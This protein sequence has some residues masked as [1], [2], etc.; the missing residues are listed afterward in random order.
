MALNLEIPILSDHPLI[1]AQTRPNKIKVFLEQLPV[2]NPFEAA[3]LLLEEIEI[4]NRQKVAVDTRINVLEIYRPVIS[5]FQK[6]LSGHYCKAKVPLSAKTKSYADM[7]KSLYLELGYGYKIALIN[8]QEKLFGI[9]NK[10]SSALCAQRALEALLNITIVYY[11][12]YLAVPGNVWAELNR[13][14]LHANQEA[15]EDIE[16][17]IGNQKKSTVAMTF[18]QML[19]MQ[20]SIPQNLSQADIKLTAEYI[21]KNA[22]YASIEPYSAPGLRTHN[23]ADNSN[24]QHQLAAAKPPAPEFIVPLATELPPT[25]LRAD[26]PAY[27]QH[28]DFVLKTNNLISKIQ[29]DIETIRHRSTQADSLHTAKSSDVKHLDLLHYLGRHWG[30]FPKRRFSRIKKL[31]SIEVN[32]G[33]S[34]IHYFLNSETS[35]M[36][37]GINNTSDLLQAMKAYQAIEPVEHPPK[38]SRW[39]SFNMSASGFALRKPQEVDETIRVGDLISIRETGHRNWSLAV[40]KWIIVNAQQKLDVGIQLVAPGATAKTARKAQASETE[41]PQTRQA[42]TEKILLVSSVPV[43]KQAVSIIAP[44]GMYRPSSQLEL[45][46]K[47]ELLKIVITKLIERTSSYER[48]SFSYLST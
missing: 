44:A 27:N 46:E 48:F 37:E 8:H 12:S 1:I 4:L 43:L 23:E 13:L 2:A 32:V 35:A 41:Q 39:I 22:H 34:A 15:I 6:L 33:I 30:A 26:K 9:G 18:K 11:Q 14:F 31:G 20:L 5:N 17:D 45:V 3:R 28:T 19:L 47:G 38:T 25:A 29:K 36:N 21:A 40:I 24:I 10:N 7:I 42:P 16:V